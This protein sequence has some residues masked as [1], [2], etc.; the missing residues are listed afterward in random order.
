M[1]SRPTIFR[2]SIPQFAPGHF[3]RNARL[4]QHV[5][6]VADRQGIT[7]AQLALAWLIGRDE[8]IV[9]I[10]GTRK[11]ASLVSNVQAVD[12]SLASEVLEA[13]DEL[14]PQEAVAGERWPSQLMDQPDHSDSRSEN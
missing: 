11:R 12:V 5:R 7:A 10:F 4:A 14:A 3:E 8:R 13:L 9:P 2:R 6:E 1:T